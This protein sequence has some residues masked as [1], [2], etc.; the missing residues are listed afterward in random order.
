MIIIK[1][2]IINC[3]PLNQI[4]A[5]ISENKENKNRYAN[6]DAQI[7]N[8][9]FSSFVVVTCEIKI[10]RARVFACLK[11]HIRVTEKYFSH[12]RRNLSK[13]TSFL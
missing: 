3:K 8:N 5:K 9:A 7:C 12:M 13:Y 4:P 2:R 10:L 11:G 6:L 1:K